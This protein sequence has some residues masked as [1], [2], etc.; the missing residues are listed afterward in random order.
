MWLREGFAGEVAGGHP[1]RAL[2]AIVWI[3]KALKSEGAFLLLQIH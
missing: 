2:S 3:Q 1:Q